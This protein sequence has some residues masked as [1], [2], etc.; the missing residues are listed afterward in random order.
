[1]LKVYENIC[2]IIL[3]N[4]NNY[5][6]NTL[7]ND[8]IKFF[9]EI[10]QRKRNQKNTKQIRDLIL[11]KKDQNKIN[12]YKKTIKSVYIPKK[13]VPE[14]FNPKFFSMSK[15]SS[16]SYSIKSKKEMELQSFI[17]FE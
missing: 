6:K 7:N 17:S 11:K 8:S 2:E 13:K 5:K 4:H 12:I 1:M 9:S 16:K 10:Y 14:Q 3:E 15:N